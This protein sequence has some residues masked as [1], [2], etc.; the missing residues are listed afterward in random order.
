MPFTSPY[1]FGTSRELYP[2]QIKFEPGPVGTGT[3]GIIIF[4]S[5]ITVIS[6][7]SNYFGTPSSYG[8]YDYISFNTFGSYTFEVIENTLSGS[9]NLDNLDLVELQENT[10]QTFVDQTIFT[11][12]DSTSGALFP[13][14][15]KTIADGPFNDALATKMVFSTGARSLTGYVTIG[16]KLN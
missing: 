12:Y 3:S 10:F 15:T 14:T 11:V 5:T 4:D 13:T 9:S 8:A 16:I 2:A 1:M 7:S 6:D